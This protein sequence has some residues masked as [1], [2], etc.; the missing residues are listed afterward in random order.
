MKDVKDNMHKSSSLDKD[1]QRTYNLM[2]LYNMNR[3]LHAAL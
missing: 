3:G 1:I 2:I